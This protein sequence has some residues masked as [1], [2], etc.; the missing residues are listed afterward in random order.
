MCEREIKDQNQII[1]DLYFNNDFENKNKINIGIKKKINGYKSQDKK[2]KD[3][4]KR[5]YKL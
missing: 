2:E 3:I 5:F 4:A 1:I